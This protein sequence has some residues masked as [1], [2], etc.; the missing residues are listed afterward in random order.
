[1]RETAFLDVT[2]TTREVI[3]G[4]RSDGNYMKKL[5]MT[6]ST[7]RLGILA[8]CHKWRPFDVK[9]KKV[10]SY[11]LKL[12]KAQDRSIKSGNGVQ[13]VRTQKSNS[14]NSIRNDSNKDRCSVSKNTGCKLIRF[15]NAE[16][17]RQ[18]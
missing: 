17:K 18:N 1:M 6:F 14:N 16:Y 15:Q 7:T 4:S 3:C 11:G 9:E 10:S 2:L 5:N 8:V 13:Q 12:T